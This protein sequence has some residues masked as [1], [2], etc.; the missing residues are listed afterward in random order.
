[1]ISSF[2][3]EVLGLGLPRKAIRVYG[4]TAPRGLAVEVVPW[5]SRSRAFLEGATLAGAIFLLPALLLLGAMGLE[6]LAMLLVVSTIGGFIRFWWLRAR[7]APLD[8]Q[9]EAL[10]EGDLILSLTIDEDRYA[11]VQQTLAR[12]HPELM[13]LGSDPA[14]SPPFP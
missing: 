10:R 6:A 7:I 9:E 13:I 4:N 5:R 12:R 8:P 3:G 14:G 1:M 11:A 2:I